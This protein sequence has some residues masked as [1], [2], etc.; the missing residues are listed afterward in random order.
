MGFEGSELFVLREKA[1]K[2]IVRER[3]HV[4]LLYYIFGSTSNGTK[5]NSG[6]VKLILVYLIVFE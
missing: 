6:D 4:P 1:E 2:K 5:I 3:S